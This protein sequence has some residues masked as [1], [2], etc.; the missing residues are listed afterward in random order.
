MKIMVIHFVFLIRLSGLPTVVSG[1]MGGN[2][3]NNGHLP[4]LAADSYEKCMEAL[5]SLISSQKRG[6]GSKREAKFALMLKYMKVTMIVFGRLH[7][8][9]ANFCY[10]FILGFAYCGYY[11]LNFYVPFLFYFV[12]NLISVLRKKGMFL[13][14]T[15][16]ILIP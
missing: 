5:S 1:E 6:D 10:N 15:F 2:E 9:M 7:S 14:V 4:E 12:L 3:F 13:N 11:H 16:D 8:M